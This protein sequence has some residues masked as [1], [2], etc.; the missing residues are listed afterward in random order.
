MKFWVELH[1]RDDC[2]AEVVEKLSV[3]SYEDMVA[4]SK[5]MKIAGLNHLPYWTRRSKKEDRYEVGTFHALSID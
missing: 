3:D 2:G 1:G 5:Q 4:A